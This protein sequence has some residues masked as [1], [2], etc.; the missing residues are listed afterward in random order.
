[1]CCKYVKEFNE[2]L[3]GT[4]DKEEKCRHS[5]KTYCACHRTKNSLLLEFGCVCEFC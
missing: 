1:M 3:V 2:N 5:D 4:V